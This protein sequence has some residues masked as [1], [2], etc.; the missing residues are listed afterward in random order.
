[1][2]F[3]I[4]SKKPFNELAET[5]SKAFASLNANYLRQQQQRQ[6]LKELNQAIFSDI[7]AATD[8]L[9]RLD[10]WL[11]VL[12]S[13]QEQGNVLLVGAVYRNL[14][15]VFA[16]KELRDLQGH[17]LE[18]DQVLLHT[19]SIR[20][21]HPEHQTQFVMEGFETAEEIE[22]KL[23]I[24]E[25]S[26]SCQGQFKKIKA[27]A[28]LARAVQAHQLFL[29]RQAQRNEFD[30]GSLSPHR[31]LADS[32]GSQ[33]SLASNE[34]HS[35]T[36][37][38][39]SLQRQESQL[40]VIDIENKVKVKVEY[41]K[42]IY[43]ALR[44]KQSFPLGNFLNNLKSADSYLT[45][46]NTITTHV[47]AAQPRLLMPASVTAWQKVHNFD[48]SK[49]PEEPLLGQ[50]V[51]AFLAIYDRLRKF[52][53]GFSD[54]A[55]QLKGL[56]P[57]AQWVAIEHPALA[58]S[59]SRSARAWAFAQDA[60]KLG[61]SFATEINGKGL[62]LSDFKTKQWL[63]TEVLGKTHPVNGHD[64]AMS[65]HRNAYADSLKKNVVV[66]KGMQYT[67]K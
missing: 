41:F 5:L 43:T 48:F 67:Q 44:A 38:A 46:L 60:V 34:S 55:A 23:P 16:T 21:P 47:K 6:L 12:L 66:V 26:E 27:D 56:S 58:N 57:L 39:A 37:A 24:F 1:M 50:S 19:L 28:E 11:S 32:Y 64:K 52:E 42:G 9:A 10:Y 35:E 59:T 36:I 62:I 65:V 45:Q 4:D 22:F 20:Y 49:V 25:P 61:L 29:E 53:A 8:L 51:T 13:L 2:S 33:M 40:K 14:E 31:S 54:F 3:D 30:S 15:R 17:L 63:L 18:H 7:N